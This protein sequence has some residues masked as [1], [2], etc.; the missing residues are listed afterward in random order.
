MKNCT[1]CKEIKSL[2]FFYKDNSKKSGL[3]SWCK[4]CDGKKPS[5]NKN[6]ALYQSVWNL[7]NKE[8]IQ[9]HTKV[10]SALLSGK[11]IKTPCVICGNIKS[12]GHHFDYSMPLDIVWLCKKHHKETHQIS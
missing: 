12:E 8:K 2:E 6:H 11:I 7:R 4:A 10:R 1:K 3:S 9:A 5:A